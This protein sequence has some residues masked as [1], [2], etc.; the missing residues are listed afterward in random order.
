MTQGNDFL[1]WL[2]EDYGD[3]RVQRRLEGEL[4]NAY[5]MQARQ[6]STLR[7]QMDRIQGTLEQRLDRLAK[8]FYAFVELSDVRADLAVFEDET[9]V[10]HA[11]QRLLRALLG[12]GPDATARPGDVPDLSAGLPRC[13]GYWLRPAVLSLTANASGDQDAAAS[14]LVDA[15]ELD[16][17]RAAAFLTAGL[18]VAG[19]APLALPLLGA[20]FQ[21]AGEQVTYAQR[22]LW[23]AC[24]HGVYG[25]PGEAMIRD[26]L[27]G[28]VRGLDPTAA[29]AQQEKWAQ[30]ADTTF[31]ASAL[32]TQARKGLPRG[33]VDVD[34][35]FVPLVAARRLNAL[36]T[37]IREAMTGEPP[38]PGQ[39]E[40]AGAAD[41]GSPVA[42]LAAVAAALA[43]EGS[44]EEIALRQR[45][46][47]LREVIDDQKTAAR[48]S[49]DAAAGSTLTLLLGDAFGTDLRLRRVALMACAEWVTRLATQLADAATVPPPDQ[50]SLT[51]EG[52][53]VQLS[54]SGE[55]SLKAVFAEIEEHNA[56][57]NVGAK[58]FKKKEIAEEIAWEE[59][60]VSRDVGQASAAYTERVA[61]LRTAA[62]QATA[63]RDAIMGALGG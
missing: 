36:S 50:I 40:K 16:A 11:A 34:G 18:A 30:R 54:A 28:Y 33:L 10:R 32:T 49:W 58:L 56:P 48:P 35:L 42:A 20:A 2:N 62:T 21:A 43:E 31:G 38:R 17:A 52:H 26:W 55:T 13:S 12:N 46:R 5:D 44:A 53:A 15:Q 27:S 57:Q 61:E 4:Q 47:E 19:Q 25:D 39:E 22:A 41:Q 23:Q 6:A 7:S 1:D 51:V 24:A 14:A 8:A 3:R 37:W 9:T 29:A 63:D 60:R 59:D 45:A